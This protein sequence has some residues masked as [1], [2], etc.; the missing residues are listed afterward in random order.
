VIVEADRGHVRPAELVAA[1]S[2]S[3]HLGFGQPMERVL[4]AAG[5]GQSRSPRRDH[6]SVFEVEGVV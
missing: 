6:H 3:I 4:P 2:L 1:L 5:R